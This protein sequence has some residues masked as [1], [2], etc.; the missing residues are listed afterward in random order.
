[1][2]L[3]DN[4]PLTVAAPTDGVFRSVDAGLHGPLARHHLAVLA[5]EEGQLADAENHWRTLLAQTPAFPPARLGLAELFVR[6]ERW[7]ELETILT[8][9]EPQAP[10][11]AAV[12]RARMHLARKNS[13]PRDNCSKKPSVKR[14]RA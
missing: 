2:Q 14:H 9:L 12:L 10:V 3:L 13:P 5:R 4:R 1:M 8:E 6:Q 11:D 7:P